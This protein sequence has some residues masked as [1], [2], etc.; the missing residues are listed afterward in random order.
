MSKASIQI[1]YNGKSYTSD[2]IER[3]E[4]ELEKLEEIC[5]L[6]AQGKSTYLTFQTGNKKYFFPEKILN[7]SIISIIYTN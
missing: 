6:S 4:E 7:A 5:I 1:E 2:S 3:S